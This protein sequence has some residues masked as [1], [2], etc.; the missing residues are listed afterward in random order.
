MEES[1][2]LG[3]GFSSVLTSSAGSNKLT[4]SGRLDFVVMCRAIG[5]GAAGVEEWIGELGDSDSFLTGV[6]CVVFVMFCNGRVTINS[7]SMPCNDMFD[8]HIKID[9]EREH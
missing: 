1:V 5:G 8:L 6:S 7:K 2:N 9:Y 3:R 4:G